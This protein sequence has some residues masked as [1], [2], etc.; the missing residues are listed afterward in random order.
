[1]ER[2]KERV[3]CG[4]EMTVSV[5]SGPRKNDGLRSG[6]V[7]RKGEEGKGKGKGKGKM[8]ILL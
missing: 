4:N 8:I 6:R 5:V 3:W 7:G 2:G 1:M